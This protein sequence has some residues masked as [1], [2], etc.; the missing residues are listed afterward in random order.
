MPLLKGS[1]QKVISE[2]IRRLRNEGYPQDQA[3]VIAHSHAG[4]SKKKRG[5]K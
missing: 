4:K 3:V 5:K 2:N 1:S